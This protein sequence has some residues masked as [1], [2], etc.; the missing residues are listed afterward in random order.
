MTAGPPTVR[1]ANSGVYVGG[2]NLAPLA[3]VE[4]DGSALESAMHPVAIGAQ[5]G[6]PSQPHV[7]G[8]NNLWQCSGALLLSLTVLVNTQCS[9]QPCIASK[10]AQKEE[11]MD[12]SN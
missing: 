9:T 2:G 12:M 7:L 11:A 8:R 4:A 3:I 6:L 10:Q 1:T 5:L